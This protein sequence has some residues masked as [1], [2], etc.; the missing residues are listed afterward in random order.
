M[1]EIVNTDGFAKL[2]ATLQM[3]IK[4]PFYNSTMDVANLGLSLNSS[5][6]FMMD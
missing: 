5:I 6:Q 4:N 2:H 3:H 1:I